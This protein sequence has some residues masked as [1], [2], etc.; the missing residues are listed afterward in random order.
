M[1]LPHSAKYFSANRK[2][3]I[4][5]DALILFPVKR[6]M[7][8]YKIFCLFLKKFFNQWNNH[9]ALFEVRCERGYFTN[10]FTMATR[11]Y[12]QFP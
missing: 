4:I 5:S 6:I 1:L 12:G 8:Q 2:K 9:V 10:V 7:H 3:Q 11:N